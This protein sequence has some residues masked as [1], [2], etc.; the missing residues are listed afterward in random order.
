MAV[1]YEAVKKS[2]ISNFFTVNNFY[3]TGFISGFKYRK[4]IPL[5]SV[6]GQAIEILKTE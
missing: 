3:F 4:Y 2:E 1:N 6:T 5:P